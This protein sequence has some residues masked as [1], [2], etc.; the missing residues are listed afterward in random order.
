MCILWER[1][2]SNNIFC[3]ILLVVMSSDFKYFYFNKFRII[4]MKTKNF[5]PKR[6]F[7][8]GKIVEYYD[9]GKGYPVLLIHGWLFS[10]VILRILIKELLEGG[11]EGG[12]KF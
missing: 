5:Q 10:K 11:R 1:S 6:I 12:R 3:E 7:M 9:E 2:E 8:D 4:E